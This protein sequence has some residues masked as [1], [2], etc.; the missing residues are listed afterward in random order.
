MK[1]ILFVLCVIILTEFVFSCFSTSNVDMDLDK[2]TV[3][4]LDDALQCDS[5]LLSTIVE[6]P[7]VISLETKDN[8]LLRRIRAIEVCDDRIY[9]LDDMSCSMLV[10]SRDGSF[11]SKVGERGRG[12]GEY[13]EL[14][15]FSLD[16]DNNIIYLWDETLNT[17]FLYDMK[18]TKYLTEI[19][20]KR[21]GTKSFCLLYFDNYLYLNQTSKKDDDENCE[22]I[23]I[24]KTTG[25]QCEFY[26]K[27][28]DYNKGWNYPM[29]LSCSFFY[30]KNTV[31]PKYVGVF[32]DYI[33]SITSEG[34]LPAYHIQS[35]DFVNKEE[36]DKLKRD[37]KSNEYVCDLSL[38][39]R[40]A[41]VFMISHLFEM[42]DMLTFQFMKDKLY[43]AFYNM[44]T[45][46]TCYTTYIKNDYLGFNNSFATDFC[47][48]DKDGIYGLLSQEQIPSFINKMV[49]SNHLSPHIDNYDKL[50]SIQQDSNPILFY[51]KYK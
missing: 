33:F 26:L 20:I 31:S 11:I 9:I 15:D 19:R 45:G 22:I 18:T 29:R 16:R 49:E 24:D 36:I 28:S 7:E 2:A 46:E 10:F 48:S 4:N 13:L 50:M 3:I 51:Y 38:L 42:K 32:S 44:H 47:Y 14:A 39:Y 12:R 23:R 34:V 8:C 40:K 43:Y 6:E 5:I 25:E 21:N 17:V 35:K 37:A 27:S 1:K 41:P 30:S